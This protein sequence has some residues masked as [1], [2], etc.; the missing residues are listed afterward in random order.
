MAIPIIGSSRPALEGE[1]TPLPAIPRDFP[2][3]GSAP[4]SKRALED[5]RIEGLLRHENAFVRAYGVEQASRLEGEEWSQAILSL[6]SDPDEAVASDAIHAMELRKYRPAID[7]ILERFRTA[8]RDLVAVSAS[9]LGELAPERLLEA[10]R[11]R[12]RLDDEGYAATATALACIASSEVVEFLEK[13][14]NRA[15]ALTPERRGALYGAALLSGNPELSSRVIGLALDDSKS[16]E[17]EGAS[18]PTRSA[19]AAIAGAP[20]P[21]S[22]RAAGL[23][24]YDIARAALEADVAPLLAEPERAALE[25]ALKSKRPGAVLAA[26]APVLRRPDRELPG[27]AAELG[28]MPRRRRGLLAA[29]IARKDALDGLPLNAAA[30]FIAAAAHATSIIVAGDANDAP[31]LA[32]LAKALE[33]DFDATKVASMPKDELRKLF[34]TRTERQM[35]RVHGILTHETFRSATTLRRLASAVVEA[36]HGE[37][38][39]EAAADVDGTGLHEIAVKALSE[40]PERGEA[41][42]ISVLERVPLEP[43]LARLALRAA[44]ELRTE[45]VALAIGRRFSDLREIARSPLIRAVLRVGDARL[46]PSIESRA[47]REEPEE[48][49]WVI[50]SLVHGREKTGK[51]AD[52][53][54][55]M[56]RKSGVAAHPEHAGEAPE[57]RVHVPLRCKRCKE[58]LT[59]GFERILLDVEAR[60]HYGDPAFTGDVECKACGAEEELEPTEEAGRILT[61]HMLQ[62]LADAKRGEIEEAPLVSPAQTE[63]RGRKMGLAAALRAL[64]QEIQASPSSIRA[65]LHRAR[66]HLILKRRRIVEDLDAVLEADPR[67]AEALS[68]RAAV[69]ARARD[70][71]K[72]FE[73]TAE[74][75]RWTLSDPPPRFYDIDDV[76]TFREN[77]EDYLLELES[78]T[79][80]SP[81]A[82]LDLEAARSR[83]R[84]REAL[85]RRRTTEDAEAA[86]PRS[87]SSAPSDNEDSSRAATADTFERAG[88][89]DPCPC[90]SG[91]KFKK[92]H[93]RGR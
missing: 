5:D 50:L 67:S 41:I 87:A 66:L 83:R 24:M 17:P 77:L 52:A 57:R 63:L 40:H 44:E 54:H 29:L 45:R 26:L 14:L 74:A 32:A 49:A 37:G 34:E 46:I 9:A 3:P 68:L 72:A 81:P 23:E 25:D 88:R 43:K 21:Y 53:L 93:G 36:G 56:E 64:D 84:E 91:K 33:G 10:V 1:T 15:G 18:Y 90:G 2:P 27:E 39:L 92:C 73:L 4:P 8:S 79:G 69:A 6:V 62:F 65:R 76:R 7:A 16:E 60:D 51:L 70:L 59:Y 82:D 11:S 71:G 48:L 89:N 12:G 28:T 13:A 47:F 55:R 78:A 42:L 38:L 58:T 75:L 20:L 80:A 86:R 19:L 30:V 22:R 61:A 85:R 35:R 31:A